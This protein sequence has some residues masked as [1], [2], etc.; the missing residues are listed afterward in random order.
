[1]TTHPP[2]DRQAPTGAF[3]VLD[4]ED[5][6]RISGAEALP[7]FLMTLASD[8]DLW[9]FVS[10]RGGLTAG[11]VDPD[12]CLFPYETVDKL[13]D[14]HHHTG[15]ITLLRVQRQGSPAVLW[16]PFG[17]ASP[18][19]ASC[20]RNLYKNIIGNRLVF[21]EVRADLELA[22]RY[23][24]SAS[25]E[26]GLVRT[27]TLENR[28]SRPL[29]ID[30]LD[31][32]RNIM[33]YGVPLA[34]QQQSSCLV[35]AY[36]QSECDAETG[37]GI[38][39]LTAEIV[40]RAEPAEELR[41][42]TVW[43]HGLDP[44]TVC[45]SLDAVAAFE[46]GEPARFEGTLSGRRGNYLVVSSLDLEPGAPARW[47][48]AADVG[49]SHVQVAA[50]RRLLLA[51]GDLGEEIEASLQRSS[52]GLLRLVASADGIQRTGNTA[53]AVHHFANVLFNNMRGG[54]FGA[55]L[56]AASGRFRGLPRPAQPAGGRAPPG[57]RREPAGHAHDDGPPGR[58]A[59]HFGCRSPPARLR[60]PAAPLR[61]PARRS[62]PPLESLRHPRSQS[63][64]QPG[65]ALRGQLARHLPELGS[66][67]AELPGLP[68]RTSSPSSSTLPPSTGST[69]IGSPARASI[70]RSP[71][72]TI[73]G[74]TSATGGTTR[75]STC[76]DSW[77]RSR[78]PHP[79]ALEELL[80]QEIFSYAE[81]PY[82]LE[83]YEK[84]V[85]HPR[86]TI[87]YDIEAAGRIASRVRTPRGRRQARPP[88]GRGRVHHVN[89]LE[90]LLV[91]ALSKLSNFVPVGGIWM[92]TQRPE[93]NDANNALAGNGV[94]MVTLCHLRRYL[95]F[96]ERLL[97]GQADARAS[98]SVEVAVWLAARAGGPCRGARPARCRP[99]P[100][101]GPAG[102]CWMR[103]G[104][105][106]HRTGPRCTRAASPARSGCGWPTSSP[107]AARRA[108]CLDQAIRA[109]RREDGLYHAYNLLEI[110][111]RPRRPGDPPPVR[112]ARGTGRGLEF[113]GG[114]CGGGRASSC[115][116][117]SRAAFTGRT[118]GASSLSGARA[119][120][121][122]RQE[123]RSGGARRARCR[124]CWTSCAPVIPR[125]WRAMPSASAASRPTS[126]TRSI[127]RRPSTGSPSGKSGRRA[128][129]RDRQAVLD[130][131]E[132]VFDHRSFT[133]RSGT[134]Y[135][136]EGLGSVYWHMVAKLLL[137]VQEVTLRAAARRAA[138]SGRARRSSTATT[139]FAPVSVS[140]RPSPS[141]APFPPTRT[142]TPR[143]AGARSSRA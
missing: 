68:A 12:G 116:R 53:A 118:S 54:V 88:I 83:P 59:G 111:R 40:D 13:H 122:P 1:M 80:G 63:G 39:A 78:V 99:A 44:F 45:L 52:E 24:W 15:P 4:G 67:G 73:P 11:R 97:A 86:A 64:W 48:L 33:P 92:N 51:G 58:G 70:G 37:L 133:G 123:R 23:R 137:A 89:L 47:H 19:G 90:K 50:L 113:G 25:D 115:R 129:A 6:Y 128:V 142:R 120:G 96:L 108:S 14:G 65:A 140:R 102:G 17:V 76:C 79:A 66:A 18:A 34:L 105:R 139:A 42:N 82:R 103:W 100:G 60:V 7:P 49:R 5:Y 81:V 138:R 32:L 56:R 31:G 119:A 114:G 101:G 75:S 130:V 57:A 55:E 43:C 124:S 27:S 112:D 21:E 94:S 71:T 93:W 87:D 126:G 41:A 106:S 26:F 125:S 132:V 61:P 117:S 109:N 3:T 107:S 2:V 110:D 85:E 22:F 9:M 91:P 84:I 36:K 95:A 104:S 72:P 35:D 16:Q 77:R 141:T 135:G 134:M 131:F 28:G 29:R 74:A 8:T 20:E 98:I 10:S 121:I 30:L 69:P 136:Y 143:P 46:R 127:S 62:E 38:F